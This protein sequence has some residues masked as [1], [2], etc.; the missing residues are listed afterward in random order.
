MSLTIPFYT[1]QSLACLY[2]WVLAWTL[3]SATKR[4]LVTGC[5]FPGSDQQESATPPPPRPISF[6]AEPD[7]LAL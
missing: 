4:P 7:A 6:L 2:L 1:L 5:R 3:L